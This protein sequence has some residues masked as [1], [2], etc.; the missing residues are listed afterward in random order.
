MID[1][2]SAIMYV[3]GK[4][5]GESKA[6]KSVIKKSQAKNQK[7]S[8]PD[9]VHGCIT[10][11]EG[12]FDNFNIVPFTPGEKI[13]KIS[14]ITG[15][16]LAVKPRK[17]NNTCL[18]KT[19]VN[20]FDVADYTIE[21]LTRMGGMNIGATTIVIDFY[22]AYEKLV[23][24]SEDVI[25]VTTFKGWYNKLSVSQIENIH[26]LDIKN[27][28]CTQLKDFLD[29]FN[30]VPKIT[31]LIMNPPYDGALH[32][33]FLKAVCGIGENW[34]NVD[35]VVSVQPGGWLYN[36]RHNSDGYKDRIKFI[37]AGTKI[38]KIKFFNGNAVFK[39]GSFVPIAVISVNSNKNNQNVEVISNTWENRKE[40]TCTVPIDKINPFMDGRIDLFDSIHDK[41]IS[42]TQKI[43]LYDNIH[44]KSKNDYN[45][46]ISYIL[47]TP[48]KKDSNT[49]KMYTADF[50]KLQTRKGVQVDGNGVMNKINFD[51]QAYDAVKMECRED[52]SKSTPHFGTYD[53]AV[54]YSEYLKTVFVTFCLIVFKD[55]QHIDHGKLLQFIPGMTDY[56]QPWT[57]D[58]IYKHMG[59]N[60]EE[61]SY[62]QEMVNRWKS[63]N[64]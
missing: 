62:I 11:P 63:S 6:A 36:K 61:I 48:Y 20:G 59:F 26:Y 50:F 9:T 46:P 32:I 13:G 60:Q 55:T 58:R 47:G 8:A 3:G 27:D 35:N 51:D 25:F 33:K 1:I 16:P 14:T 54:N 19:W 44:K 24:L 5:S 18:Q 41:I 30:M 2:I 49:T 7:M 39:I 23:E 17:T 28:I 53:E 12:C 43:S 64:Q 22:D 52:G 10:F 29:I 4:V 40:T 57:D 34:I 37:D 45:V 21:E 56:T 31:N 15:L 38:D 42:S